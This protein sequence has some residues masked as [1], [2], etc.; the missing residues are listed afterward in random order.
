MSHRQ[1]ERTLYLALLS[2]LCSHSD[3]FMSEVDVIIVGAGAAGIAAGIEFQQSSLQYLVLE[4]R[5]RIGGR[6][7]TDRETFGTT[8]VDLGATWIHGFERNHILHD[9]FQELH[10]DCEPESSRSMIV[11]YDGTSITPMI[12]QRAMQIYSQLD[13]RIQNFAK[14]PRTEDDRSVENVIENDYR[15]LV[16]ED[17]PVK[18][19]VDFLLSATEQYEASN[20]RNLSAKCWGMGS[21]DGDDQSVSFGYGTLLEKIVEKH[22]LSIRLNAFVTEIDSSDPDRIRVRLKD[23]SV[24]LY[25]RRLIVTVPLGC[26]KRRTIQFNPPLPDWKVKAIEGMGFGLMNKLILQFPNCFWNATISGILH[27]SREQRGRF[28]SMLCSPPPKN[29]LIFLVTGDFALELEQLN[30]EQII[31]LVVA[32]LNQIFPEVEIPRP[33]RFLFTRWSQDPFAF[34]SYSNFAVHSSPTTV[35]LLARSTADGRIHWAG[36]HANVNDGTDQW[37]IGCVHSAFQSGRNAAR[38]I[39]N[40]LLIPGQ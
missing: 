22:Q 11:D 35:E 27:F 13:V 5:N 29:M 19:T 36:E 8:A 39:C 25:C 12:W 3:N 16:P 30:D 37:S 18:R 31:D 40:D 9:Y 20:L 28:R 7:W 23:E 15:T 4:G 14:S 21:S 1:R 26:L 38:M 33:N 34:G 32:F 6:A 2:F 17:G 24:D 10:G